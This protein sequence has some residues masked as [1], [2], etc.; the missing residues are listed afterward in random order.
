MPFAAERYFGLGRVIAIA[1]D[2][3]GLSPEQ[4]KNLLSPAL[5]E[6]DVNFRVTIEGKRLVVQGRP[7]MEAP[8]GVPV[9]RVLKKQISG[10]P[11]TLLAPVV[12]RPTY[13][14]RS[15]D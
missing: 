7:T 3:W 1:T 15:G 13:P 9:Y 12:F 5:N 11:W 14:T 8:Q 2:S 4:W 6:R 10:A